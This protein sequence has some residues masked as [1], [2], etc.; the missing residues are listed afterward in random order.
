LRDSNVYLDHINGTNHQ[1]KLGFS[2]RVEKSTVS[3]VRDRL[4]ALK[5]KKEGGGKIPTFS[6]SNSS[7]SSSSSASIITSIETSIRPIPVVK[8]ISLDIKKEDSKKKKQ[9]L[10]EDTYNNVDDPDDPDAAALR[11]TLGFSGFR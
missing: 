2:M 9:R 8:D 6:S 10:E 4:K 5:E 3:S 1:R 11:S 7:S